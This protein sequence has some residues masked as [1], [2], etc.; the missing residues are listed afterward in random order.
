MFASDGTDARTLRGHRARVGALA[1]NPDGHTPATGSDDG[2][3]WL[4]DAASGD[5]HRVGTTAGQITR[6][7]WSDAGF[8][9]GDDRGNIMVWKPDGSASRRLGAHGDRISS[10]TYAP[11]GLLISTS[12][13]RSARVWRVDSGDY[14]ALL[15]HSDAVNDAAIADDGKSLITASFDRTARVW[16]LT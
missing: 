14:R 1:F 11:G 4:W 8:A 6:L 13:D 16:P 9:S 3:V 15:G 12:V 7:A 5:G 10:L 2:E